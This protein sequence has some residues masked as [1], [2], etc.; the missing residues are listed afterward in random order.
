MLGAKVD[1]V[2]DNDANRALPGQTRSKYCS[3]YACFS[4]TSPSSGGG[5]SIDQRPNISPAY[6]PWSGWRKTS[7]RQ[8]A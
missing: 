3:T 2:L 6:Q 7:M 8:A 1:K 4:D 5:F